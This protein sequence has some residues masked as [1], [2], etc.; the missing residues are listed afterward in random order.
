MMAALIF[1][2]S[3]VALLQFFLSYCRS[4]IA[5]SRKVE[6]SESV[7]EVTG[8]EDHKVTAEDFQRLHQLVHLCPE[9]GGDTA[10]LRA[11]G[12]YYGMLGAL[13]MPLRGLAPA[14]A[15]WVDR[16]RANCS[17][18][19]AVALDARISRTRHL[20]EEQESDRF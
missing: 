18:F 11:I 19:A 8:I 17:Y 14:A 4:L 7:R 12:A 9:S 10:S 16:E 13:R 3:I 20:L 1:V 15:G 2:I 5:A 6:L